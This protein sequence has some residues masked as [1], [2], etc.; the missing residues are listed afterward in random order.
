MSPKQI[1]NNNV[2]HFSAGLNNANKNSIK[3]HKSELM[4]EN[5]NNNNFEINNS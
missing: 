2:F 5:N 3:L 1:E 4:P